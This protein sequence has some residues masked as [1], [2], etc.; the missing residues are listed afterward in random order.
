M[1]HLLQLILSQMGFSLRS[2]A[3]LHIENLA[4]RHLAARL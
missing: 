1:I 4:L 3:E 2:R